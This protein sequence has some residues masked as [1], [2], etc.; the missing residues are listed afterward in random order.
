MFSIHL[1][2]TGKKSRSQAS[3]DDDDFI[4]PSDSDIEV[5]STKSSSSR[6]STSR[7]S[8]ETDYSSEDGDRD[9]DEA[10]KTKAKSKVKSGSKKSN[11]ADGTSSNGFTM[12]TAAEQRAQGKKDEKKAA[13]SPYGFLA[14][15]RDVRE[16]L[17]ILIIA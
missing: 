11:A 12:L 6:S 14:E 5:K 17:L 2:F 13:E 16:L 7:R 4:V 15:I 9:E 10:P 8:A 1:F 3:D